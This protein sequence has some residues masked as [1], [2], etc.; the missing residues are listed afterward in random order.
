MTTSAAQ[1][2]FFTVPPPRVTIS[3]S[4]EFFGVEDIVTA[5]ALR[6][7][8]SIEAEVR[9]AVRDRMRDGGEHEG[10]KER[11][12]LTSTTIGGDSPALVVYG[13]L[14]QTF[15]DEFGLQPQRAFP[16][17]RKGSPLYEWAERH[18][19]GQDIERGEARFLTPSEARAAGQFLGA[20]TAKAH[21]ERVERQIETAAFL[22]ARAIYT[23]GLPRSGDPLREPF[24][25][26]F[27][28]YLPRVQRGLEE[29]AFEAAG[30]VNGVGVY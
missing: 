27:A 5:A 3:L 28:E 23:R 22:I 17:W 12:N 30:I 6:F 8:E 11:D 15:V 25:Q 20:G 9:E 4:E 14:V 18:G 2:S 26:T 7:F 19:I 1:L 13:T 16:P 21:R 10:E 24:A 29:A